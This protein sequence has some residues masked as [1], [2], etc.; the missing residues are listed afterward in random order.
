MRIKEIICL[1]LIGWFLKNHDTISYF[2]NYLVGQMTNPLKINTN[3][4]LARFCICLANFCFFSH[5][6]D[7]FNLETQLSHR[8]KGWERCGCHLTDNAFLSSAVSP[9]E[10]WTRILGTWCPG[11]F[12]SPRVREPL[13]RMIMFVWFEPCPVFFFSFN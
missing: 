6:C 11:G 9:P 8:K 5:L 13:G 12:L 7:F 1:H 3:I 10:V 2:K 4:N